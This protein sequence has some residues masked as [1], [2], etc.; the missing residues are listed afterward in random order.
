MVKLW[1]HH[2]PTMVSPLFHHDLTMEMPRTHHHYGI[3][4]DSPCWRHGESMVRPRAPYG[5]TIPWSH[6]GPTRMVTMVSP[7]WRPMASP[8]SHNGET[9]Q[10]QHHGHHCLTMK[11]NGLSSLWHHSLTIETP[12]IHHGDAIES[13]Y[14]HHGLTMQSSSTAMPSP[15]RHQGDDLRKPGRRHGLTMTSPWSHHMNHHEV[16]METS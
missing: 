5:S 3:T 4:M 2:K 9:M 8:L 7:S 6:H 14:T 10:S 13:P 12:Q 15:W 16:A 11:T 1:S